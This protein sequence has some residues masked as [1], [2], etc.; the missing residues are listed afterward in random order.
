MVRFLYTALLRLHPARFRQRFT[1]EMLWIFDQAS[2]EGR[3][4]PLFADVLISLWRQWTLRP[5]FRQQS[6]NANRMATDGLPSFYIGAGDAPRTSALIHGG[7]LSLI[8]FGAVCYTLSHSNSHVFPFVGS[9]NHSFSHFLETHSVSA[10]PTELSAQVKMKPEPVAYRPSPYFRMMPVLMALDTDRDGII[11]T[12]E[13]ANSAV[14]L[15]TLDKNH[16]NKLSAEECGLGTP[17]PAGAALVF[18]RLHPVLAALDANHDG[19]ISASEILNAPAALLTLDKNRDGQLTE[20][21]LLPD[22]A[23]LSRSLEH[24]SRDY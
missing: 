9:H 7:V 20:G 6:A 4:A 12:S 1:E 5:Q 18:M 19:E 17:H 22:P 11:S 14:A 15:L 16:D 10:A 13:I 2:A 23:E 24:R 3:T 21:E 8:A